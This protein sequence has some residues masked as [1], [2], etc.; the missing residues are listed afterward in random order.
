MK[1]PTLQNLVM[2][3]IAACSIVALGMLAGCGGGSST[4]SGGGSAEVAPG[5]TLH[6]SQGEEVVTLDPLVATDPSSVNVVSQINEPLFRVTAEGE[7]EPWLV[8][9]V[10]KSKDQRVWTF[11]LRGGVSF[12]NGNP[13]T[14]ADVLFTLERARK[15][16]NWGSV[17]EGVE[18]IT[19]PSPS[20]FVIKNSSPAPELPALLSQWSFGIIPTNF[21]GA[22]EKEFAQHPVGTGPFVL[23]SWKRG[24]SLTLDKNDN[25]W[26]KDRPY[27]QS[28]VLQAVPN[29]QS[30]VAQLQ[31]GQLD[32]IYSPPWAQVESIENTPGLAVGDFPLGYVQYLILNSRDPLFQ[33]EKVREAVDLA[34]DRDGM[35]SAITNGHGE[36]A[37]SYIPPVIPYHDASIEPTQQDVAK[38]EQL[39]A[40]AEKEGV[41]PTVT[42]L[43]SSE[44]TFWGSGAQ[45][46]QQN[47]E[48][49]GFQ[50]SIRSSDLASLLETLAGGKFEMSTLEAYDAT[51]SPAEMI[52]AYNGYEAVFSGADTT[53]TTK[54]A[55][56]ATSAVD[57]AEREELWHRIQQILDDERYIQPVVYVPYSWALKDDL[58]GFEVGTSGIPWF[59]DAGFAK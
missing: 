55:A 14:S 49:V 45:I 34:L 23:G 42:M 7:A 28:V 50:I 4:S 27:L 58:V 1:K 53:E 51:P 36:K 52:G 3:A 44:A 11:H 25:Y 40:E 30:R 33:N 57:P 12:T 47:L 56:E 9:K 54:L 8:T 16:V 17:L 46:V 5:G 43:N 13:L 21:G 32:L 22:S 15:S 29:G 2:L 20:T 41:D 18:S 35:V 38:A 24:E 6:V 48:A 39:L 19:T 10:E 37:G 31:G 26:E 59:A